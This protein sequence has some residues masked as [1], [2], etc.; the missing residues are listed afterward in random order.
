MLALSHSF[1]QT[2]W[3]SSTSTSTAVKVL[4]RS[5]S[6][7]IASARNPDN[8]RPLQ[9]LQK[10]LPGRLYLIC[11]DVTN[12]S[13]IQVALLHSF[14]RRL[15]ESIARLLLSP[16]L[17]NHCTGANGC[18]VSMYH[19]IALPRT[20]PNF[21]TSWTLVACVLLLSWRDELQYWPTQALCAGS[22]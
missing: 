3:Q 7:V 6:R 20:P 16:F 5:D 13:S 10:R 8:A 18:N 11:M 4:Q 22:S 15:A 21:Q 19:C 17:R 14:D 1:T 2:V 12:G 9:E